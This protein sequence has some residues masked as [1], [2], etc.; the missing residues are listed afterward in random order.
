MS[1]DNDA[2]FQ[3]LFDDLAELAEYVDIHSLDNSHMTACLVI[4]GR[5]AQTIKMMQL[6]RPQK[7]E[8]GKPE[9]PLKERVEES[10]SAGHTFIISKK[11]EEG[12]WTS[13][14]SFRGTDFT[15][16]LLE[17]MG[18]CKVQVRDLRGLYLFSWVVYG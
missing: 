18:P 2:V 9:R 15:F 17:K 1:N 14:R 7:S 5:M 10:R 3:S 16:D 11:S 13:V 12:F 6:V 4:A 8:N